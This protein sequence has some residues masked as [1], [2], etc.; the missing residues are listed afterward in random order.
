[1]LYLFLIIGLK[2]GKF[3]CRVCNNGQWYEWDVRDY[4][5][6]WLF[7]VLSAVQHI[8]DFSNEQNDFM[9]L[10]AD[11]QTGRMIPEKKTKKKLSK[12]NQ[13]NYVAN[14]IQRTRQRHKKELR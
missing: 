1:M 14:V 12:T 10:K 9:L 11:F 8:F 6:L 13:T 3:V 7:W 4:I 2:T 5:W